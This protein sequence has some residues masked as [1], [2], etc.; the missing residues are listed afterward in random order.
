MLWLG[1]N[2]RALD[3]LSLPLLKVSR[4]HPIECVFPLIKSKPYSNPLQQN[5]KKANDLH[6]N[7]NS[8]YILNTLEWQLIM[9]VYIIRIA[10]QIQSNTSRK[11]TNPTWSPAVNKWGKTIK[12]TCVFV[13]CMYESHTPCSIHFHMSQI[14]HALFDICT[15]LNSS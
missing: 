14:W 12:M 9:F 4:Y 15:L 10:S 3:I 6:Y 13:F 11:M 7:Y 2:L 8:A 1:T 5:G